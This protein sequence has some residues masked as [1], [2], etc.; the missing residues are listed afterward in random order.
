MASVL[1]ILL[2]ADSERETDW[3]RNTLADGNHAATLVRVDDEARCR[4]EL[5]HGGWRP[6]FIERC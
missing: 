4:A 2:I 5:E 3:L 1:R 6:R